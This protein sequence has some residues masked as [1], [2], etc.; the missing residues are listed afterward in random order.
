MIRPRHTKRPAFREENRAFR[1]TSTGA[2]GVEPTT[3][4]LT[5]ECSAIEL[6]PISGRRATAALHPTS[7][8]THDSTTAL[9]EPFLHSCS[10]ARS[11][12]V[13]PRPRV[14]LG[15]PCGRGILSPVRLPVPPSGRTPTAH[16]Q[17]YTVGESD[18]TGG[19]Y[20]SGGV[21][22]R[23]K[24]R[25]SVAASVESSIPMRRRCKSCIP[26]RSSS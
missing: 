20:I 12:H 21:P 26:R 15:S 25:L 17:V 19:D 23:R 24:P 16:T 13:M 5:V 22:R 10:M 9:C 7:R 4:R 11:P 2:V 6:H 1:G 18:A 8:S 14:E 3:A